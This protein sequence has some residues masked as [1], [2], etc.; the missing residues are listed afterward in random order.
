[1]DV[2]FF[3]QANILKHSAQKPSIL[4]H[5]T[6]DAIDALRRE[7]LISE[8]TFEI[9]DSGYRF[10]SN[11]EDRLRLMEH[12]SVDRMA[13]SGEK[14]RGL[15]LRMGYGDKGETRLVEEYR[16]ITASIRSIYSSFFDIGQ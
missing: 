6:L 7:G 10:L 13:L 1:V 11:L 8:K 15:A 16:R 9:L 4:R 3:V 14:L 2:E 5:N 12:R